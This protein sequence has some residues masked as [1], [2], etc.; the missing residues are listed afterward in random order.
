MLLSTAYFPPAEYFALLARDMTLSP[1]RV[2]PSVVHLEA[3]ENYQKQSYRNRCYILA[4]DGPQMLQVPV[5]H[6]ADMSIRNVLVDYSTPWVVRTERAL[7]TAYETSAFFEYYSPEL[8]ALLESGEPRLWDLNLKLL[9]WCA[10][11]A[12]INCEILPTTE[13]AAPGS[14]KDDFRFSIHPKQP[15]PAIPVRPWYQVFR[16]K[17]GGFTPGLSILDL[18]FNEGPDSLSFIRA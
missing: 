11:K 9:K 12:G 4:S 5:V 17:A 13:F 7:S 1:D 6:V 16:Q 10:A 14:V 18:L 3:C 2:L 8:F 15:L